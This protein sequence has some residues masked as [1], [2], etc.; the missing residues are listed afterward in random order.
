MKSKLF[1]ISFMV[2]II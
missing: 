2:L 1:Y